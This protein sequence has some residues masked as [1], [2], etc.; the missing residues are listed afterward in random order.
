MAE[1]RED[2]II[3]KSPNQE[4]G[5]KRCHFRNPVDPKGCTLDNWT[6]ECLNTANEHYEPVVTGGY[7]PSSIRKVLAAQ[8]ANLEQATAK[9]ADG[10]ILIDRS[11][12]PERL[13]NKYVHAVWGYDPMTRTN[14]LVLVDYYDVADGFDI[15]DPAVDHACKKLVQPGCRGNKDRL[16]DLIEA[17]QSLERAIEMERLNQKLPWEIV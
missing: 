13:R 5:C 15:E 2:Y 1:K 8:I 9:R 3:V 7:G 11:S 17:K 10:P 16:Q 4:N 6:C 14:T 12:L